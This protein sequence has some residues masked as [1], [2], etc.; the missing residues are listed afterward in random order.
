[1]VWINVG[2]HMMV[3]DLFIYLLLV[4]IYRSH[5]LTPRRSRQVR[6]SGT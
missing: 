6:E 2:W 5:V 1:M 3:R 4:F